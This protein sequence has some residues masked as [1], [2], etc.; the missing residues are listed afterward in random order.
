[1][2][3]PRRGRRGRGRAGR[4]RRRPRSPASEGWARERGCSAPRRGRLHV[5]DLVQALYV[6]T[7]R[8]SGWAGCR[9]PDREMP[10]TSVEQRLGSD[11]A[12]GGRAAGNGTRS[13]TLA[14]CSSCTAAA[15]GAARALQSLGRRYEVLI[16]SAS[17]TTAARRASSGERHRQHER[18]DEADEGQQC[19]R[20]MPKGSRR[21][22]ESRRSARSVISP[23]IVAATGC[24]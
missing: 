14:S 8:P 16:A 6:E 4:G 24:R 13:R 9:A 7:R 17:S 20:T 21:G 15:R 12:P 11:R 2:T 18:E 19:P 1:M 10:E 22:S 3:T 5:D 23:R